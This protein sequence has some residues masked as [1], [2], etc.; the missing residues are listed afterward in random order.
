MDPRQKL[1]RL[2]QANDVDG[3]TAFLARRP[4]LLSAA[5]FHHG[6]TCESLDVLAYF[7]ELG[8]SVNC[9]G[10]FERCALSGAAL[11]GSMAS[12]KW[13]LA[14]GADVNGTPPGGP[15]AS[16][17]HGGHLEMVR[18]LVAH[19]AELHHRDGKPPRTA[20]DSAAL[21]GHQ[22]VVDYLRE[23]GCESILELPSPTSGVAAHLERHF[24]AVEPRRLVEIV[25][26]VSILFVRQTDQVILVTEGASDVDMS[27]PPGQEDYRRGELLL[28]LPA[29]W[30][31]GREL[32]DDP[33][34]RWPLDW[35]RELAGAVE[36]SGMW[37]GGTE[38]VII[39]NQEPPEP[40]GPGTTL[41]CWYLFIDGSD[42]SR[43]RREDGGLAHLYTM[44]PIYTEERD[45][46]KSRG[47]AEL[48]SRWKRA[49]IDWV[50]RPDRSNVALAKP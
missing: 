9:L 12:A 40:L 20:L 24:G 19:G 1:F 34:Y 45:L 49:A 17:A 47:F 22:E 44:F 4:E 25:G 33:R 48:V 30:P 39:A 42:A 11:D 10:Y 35:M 43:L 2:V 14:H 23:L 27:A 15:L 16:A 21:Q 28:R 29:T 31:T 6:V 50:I 36:E 3:V 38:P 13:L 37:L 32:L 8:M 5:Q 7:I 26:S 46:E 41:S 18:F